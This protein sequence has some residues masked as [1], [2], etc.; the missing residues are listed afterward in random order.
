MLGI[1]RENKSTVLQHMSG[2]N[3]YPRLETS[4]V[5]F[6]ESVVK[7]EMQR[8]V[9]MTGCL[10]KKSCAA[11]MESFNL[12]VSACYIILSKSYAGIIF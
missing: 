2:T 7:R 12:K 6:C 9:S 8:Y 3:I 4:V 11:D 10:M 1:M 5:E